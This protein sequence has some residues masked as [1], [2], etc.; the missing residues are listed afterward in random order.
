[1]R[2]HE[3]PDPARA[4][5]PAARAPGVPAHV[6]RVH[7]LQRGAG[8]RA[9]AQLIARVPEVEEA[10]QSEEEV[11]EVAQELL[12]EVPGAADKPAVQPFVQAAIA[13]EAGGGHSTDGVLNTIKR[14]FGA[15]K[16]HS[17][18]QATSTSGHRKTAGKVFQAIRG[19][20][21]L[22]VKGIGKLFGLG[23]TVTDA[24]PGIVNIATGGIGAAVDA[25]SLVKTIGHHNQLDALY[26]SMDESSG[27][28]Q[29][30]KY[31][32]GQ[33]RSKAVKKGIGIAGAALGIAAGALVLASN[34]VGWTVGLAGA[35]LGLGFLAYKIGRKAFGSRGKVR[36]ATARRIMD[37]MMGNQGPTE[38]MYA[39]QAAEALGLNPALLVQDESAGVELVFKKLASA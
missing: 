24:A 38:Q 34:P 32:R 6:A 29:D 35:A 11:E 15:K 19:G 3:R 31:A 22:A 18:G 8:N 10:E 13:E 2:E 30:V 36:R 28:R 21:G 37:C 26:G 12:E 23:K 14:F 5:R 16:A 7:A 39:E 33:K 20:A 27:L 4:G 1:M 25:R 17:I 9:T